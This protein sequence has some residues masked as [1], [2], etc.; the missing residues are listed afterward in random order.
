MA[1]RCRTG[2]RKDRQNHRWRHPRGRSPSLARSLGARLGPV[3]RHRHPERRSA[4]ADQRAPP[5]ARNELERLV[6]DFPTVELINVSGGKYYGRVLADMKAGTRDV[7]AAMLAS[8]L[9][10]PQQRWQALPATMRR[11]GLNAPDQARSRY[12]SKR[13]PQKG[14]LREFQ[15]RLDA[16][17]ITSRRIRTCQYHRLFRGCSEVRQSESYEPAFGNHSTSDHL[18]SIVKDTG[19]VGQTT[20]LAKHLSQIKSHGP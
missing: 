5:G 2:F 11:I 12:I 15:R 1:Q 8:G 16:C 3:A 19:N 13:P 10:R 17:P 4:C 20:P 6:R 7:A 14:G 9:A 18:L